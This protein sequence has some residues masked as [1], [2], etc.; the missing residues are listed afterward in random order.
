M[1]KTKWDNK[2]LEK[3]IKLRSEGLTWN[4]IQEHF[5]GVTPNGLRK[6]FYRTMRS[7]VKQPVL[8]KILILDIETAP[9]EVRVWGLF[10]QNIGLESVLKHTSVLSFCA[11]W[12]GSDEV[13]Y[14][15][16][17]DRKDPRDDSKIIKIVWSLLDEADIVVTHNGE[18]FDIKKLTSRFSLYQLGDPSSFKNI[19][20]CKLAKAKFGFDSNKLIH[21]TQLF[22]LKN[23]KLDH[24]KFPGNTLWNGCLAKNIEAWEEM[25]LYNINDVLSL[26]EL[27]FDFMAP[28]DKK[29][30]NFSVYSD[31]IEFRCNCGS[32]QFKKHGF[33]FTKKSKFE[34]IIC[35]VCGKEHRSS[36]NLFN[37]DKRESLKV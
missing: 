1:S 21:L 5:S 33:V 17:R 29:A 32:N 6:A 36:K 9:M 4:E 27:Y 11:K 16:N 37:K 26:E 28:F 8:P 20:T 19:D 14:F 31:N 34:R 24:K 7:E 3:L 18:K 10:N 22:P 23:K 25:R 2:D 13:M 35:K 30:P 15:D 12:R